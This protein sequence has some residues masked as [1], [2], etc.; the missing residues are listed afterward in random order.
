MKVS[1]YLWSAAGAHRSLSCLP[2]VRRRVDVKCVD[3]AATAGERHPVNHGFARSRAGYF[4][5]S[6]L[7][8]EEQP[9]TFHR[10]VWN[11]CLYFL[12]P[13]GH[14]PRNAVVSGHVYVDYS[15]SVTFSRVCE[16]SPSG[17]GGGFVGE[18]PFVAFTVVTPMSSDSSRCNFVFY[19]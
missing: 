17:S 4:C 10:S 3:T 6:L 12:L 7:R 14:G 18:T 13:A 15:W 16:S 19:E 1:L 8:R 2:R 9:E 11:E 5:R